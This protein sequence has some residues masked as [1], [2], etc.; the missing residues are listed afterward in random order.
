MIKA[1]II[2][3][4]KKARENLINYLTKYCNDIMVIAEA[5][6]VNSGLTQIT[7]MNPDIIFLDIRMQDGTGFDL[8]DRINKIDFDV[9]F[10]TAFDQYA[11]KA[12]KFSALDYILKPID[13]EELVKAVGKFKKGN[14]FSDIRS[15]LNTLFENNRELKRIALPTLD[16]YRFI[17]ISQITR[18]ESDGSYSTVYVV[19]SK[20]MLVTKLLK[21]FENMLVSHGFSRVHKSHLIN[22]NFIRD[23]IKG[24]G[25][26]VIMED[27]TEI[28]VARRRKPSLLSAL[29]K[30]GQ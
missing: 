12:F 30:W 20:K 9:I 23:Y 16:G 7:K 2:D 3:D 14:D 21:D 11:I 25:G 6:G 13:P 28:D 22:H 10:V 17:D 26:T 18:I 19:N 1:I 27:G 5:D 24:E 4:E 29:L 8:L 15:K